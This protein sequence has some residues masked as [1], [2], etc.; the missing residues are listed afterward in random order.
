MPHD[1]APTQGERVSGLVRVALAG[2]IWGT[3]PLALRAA[4]GAPT[5]KV[6]FRVFFAAVVIGTWMLVSGG[7]RE[8]RTLGKPKWRQ[9]IGQ[10]LLLT[11]NWF[12]FLT[13]LDLTTVATAELLGYTGPVLVAALTP[14]IVKE[15]FDR[16]IVVPLA[17]A[18]G[19]IVIILGQH[20]L[21]LGSGREALG[22]GLAAASALTYAALL[23]RSKKIIRGISSGALML[24]EYSVASLVLSPFV[25]YAYINGDGPGSVQS[26]AAL[27]SLGVVHTALT[28]FIFLSGLRRVR[29]DHAGVLMYA[30]PVSAVMFAALFLGEPLTLATLAGGALVV[31]G[32]ILVARIEPAQGIEAPESMTGVDGTT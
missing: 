27:V 13:A 26:Y 17:L 8:L 4:D 6:F 12:L 16:R 15:P 32:G 19:G 30:E 31:L 22:A 24:V 25:A 10:G 20:G 7:W 2:L 23:L 18:L 9:V 14:L 29:A 1:V 3:I 11:L 28:G 21:T 5:V